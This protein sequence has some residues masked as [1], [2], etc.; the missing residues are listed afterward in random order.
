MGD[1][2]KPKKK[3]E[4]PRHPWQ[5]KRLEEEKTL[6]DEYAYKNKKEI[7]KMRSILRGYRAQAR[8]LITAT[9]KQANRERNQLM[10]ALYNIG[11]LEKEAELDDVLALTI[12]DIMG[13]RLQSIVLTKKLANSIK[14]S[15]QFITHK[16]IMVANKVITS[17]SYLVSRDEEFHVKF[18]PKATVKSLLKPSK[19]V[20][21]KK[22]EVKDEKPEG[23]TVK[24]KEGAEKSAGGA[25]SG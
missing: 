24:P 2:K 15:R 19:P 5:M 20:Q 6:R 8:N 12:R 14:Q 17:P 7:N 3:F 22:E 11:L 9:T 10:K 23:A 16:H 1:P 13:R 25:V 4:G 18:N 21:L